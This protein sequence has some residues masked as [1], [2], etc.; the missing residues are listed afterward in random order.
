MKR[1]LV[2]A[3]AMTLASA[4]NLWAEEKAAPGTPVQN[5]GSGGGLVAGQSGNGVWGGKSAAQWY[6]ESIDKI[7]NLTDAQKKA[8][9]A[10]IESRDKA[11]RE[12]QAQNAEK[13]KA[14]GTAMMEAYKSKDKE[15]VAKAQKAYQDL[16]APMHEAMKKSQSDWTPSSRPSRRRSSKRAG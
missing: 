14:A 11:M 9:T 4:A 7:V 8:I 12:F 13:L 10:S 2:L 3:A 15:A 16:Y 6:I 5:A 1:L